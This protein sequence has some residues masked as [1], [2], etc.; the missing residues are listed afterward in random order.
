MSAKSIRK[1][2]GEDAQIIRAT[3]I[4]SSLHSALEE[5][6]LNAIDAHCTSIE[7]TIDFPSNSFTIVD[8]GKK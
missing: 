5:L 2:P 7:I 3:A 1:L 4:V 6:I 8:N